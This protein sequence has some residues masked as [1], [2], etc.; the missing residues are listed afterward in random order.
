MSCQPADGCHIC[1]R[2][3]GGIGRRAAVAEKVGEVVRQGVKLQ[4]DSM[5]GEVVA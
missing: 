3:A 1:G 2:R 5:D 4:P